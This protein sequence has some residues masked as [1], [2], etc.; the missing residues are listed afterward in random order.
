MDKRLIEVP[1]GTVVRLQPKPGE[2]FFPEGTVALIPFR[3]SRTKPSKENAIESSGPPNK[4]P[5]LSQVDIDN[6][7]PEEK[8]SKILAQWEWDHSPMEPP[9]DSQEKK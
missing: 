7:I 6:L 2:R 3:P 5:R 4:D 1:N 8:R 9:P